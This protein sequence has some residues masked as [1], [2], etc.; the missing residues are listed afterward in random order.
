MVLDCSVTAA[1]LFEDETSALAEAVL[2]QLGDGWAARVPP[3]WVLEVCNVLLVGERRGRLT[4]ARSTVFWETLRALP[5]AVDERASMATAPAVVALGREHQLSAYDAAYLELAVR[6]AVPV[7]TLDQ[8]LAAA[9]QASGAGV[10]APL[11]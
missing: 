6:E 7:A 9:A 11:A 3:V 1:W 4:K 2:E 8:R 5:I 10:W